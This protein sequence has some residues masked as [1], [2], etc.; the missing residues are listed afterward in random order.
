[1]KPDRD[2]YPRRDCEGEKY[3]S[4]VVCGPKYERYELRYD[5]MT[6]GA[7]VGETVTGAGGCTGV[8]TDD[9]AE[10]ATAGKLEMSDVTG[11]AD[12]LAFV[13]NEALTGSSGFSATAN[14]QAFRK[15][16]GLLYPEG[17]LAERNGKLYCRHHHRMYFDYRDRN[18]G[19]LGLSE[20]DN[21]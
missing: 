14:G 2:P 4:C 7:T 3:F 19:D 20:S 16:Y 5:A 15:Q 9:M 6:A 1:M 10:S 21:D 17:E 12:D 13:D 11:A 8:V 18:E